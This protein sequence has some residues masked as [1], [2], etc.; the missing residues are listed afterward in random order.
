[1][2]HTRIKMSKQA[3]KYFNRLDNITQGRIREGIGGLLEEPPSGDIKQLRGEFKGL[4][5]LQIGGFRIIYFT[6]GKLIKITNIFPRG[7]VYKRI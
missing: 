3:E 2:E 5:R 4:N 6:D 7:D 1:M